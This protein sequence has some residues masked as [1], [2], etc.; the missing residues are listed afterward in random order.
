ME[1]LESRHIGIY[2][3]LQLQKFDANQIWQKLNIGGGVA[4]ETRLYEGKDVLV[5]T[6]C[7]G[8]NKKVLGILDIDGKLE[9]VRTLIK[10]GH[11]AFDSSI[12][13]KSESYNCEVHLS[14][15]IGVKDNRTSK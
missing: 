2:N 3:V 14:I 12:W 8:G 7:D 4:L 10:Y 5:V 13:Q 11:D 9:V 1:T 15:N 6:C